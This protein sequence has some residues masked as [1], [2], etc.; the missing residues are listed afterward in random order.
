MHRR[1]LVIHMYFK[2]WKAVT[3]T[4]KAWLIQKMIHQEKR[5]RGPLRSCMITHLKRRISRTTRKRLQFS[6]TNCDNTTLKSV[7]EI[8]SMNP[9]IHYVIP[10]VIF[11]GIS[12]KRQ[13]DLILRFMRYVFC[14][15]EV[16]FKHVHFFGNLLAITRM[17]EF[18]INFTIQ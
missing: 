17:D 9:I 14:A 11:Y 13:F 15:S 4:R 7:R 16:F 12:K 10:L 8:S 18:I 6:G 2:V 3:S 5:K 1:S